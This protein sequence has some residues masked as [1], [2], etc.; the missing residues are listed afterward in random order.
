MPTLKE[1][2]GV[3]EVIAPPALSEPWDNSGLQVGDPGTGVKAVLVA[4]DPLPEVMAEAGRLGAGLVVT[5]HPLFFGEVRR[6]EL[7]RG[8]G[9]VVKAAVEGKIAVYSAHTS[10]D[11]A[12]MG[13]SDALASA[14]GLRATRPLAAVPGGPAGQG[15]GRVCRLP[16]P[17]KAKE[18]A[19]VIKAR[20]GVETL[21]L[22]G[23]PDAETG[24]AALCGGSG[25]SFM[26]DALA[27]GAGIYITGDLKY[28][29]A[30]K[31]LELGLPVIDV[32][33]FASERPAVPMMAGL[34]SGAFKKKRWKVAVKESH[35]QGE[36]WTWL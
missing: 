23:D 14:V 7:D 20:L 18:L 6:M 35:V 34:L 31:A 10:L 21:R 29:D 32:G 17:L 12:G 11:R 13:V 9:A 24:V 16:R 3:I 5:H 33:H 36:P 22:V 26:E 8:A 2:I 1:I 30:L 28:H 25:A 19:R 4:L 15:Y 27:A